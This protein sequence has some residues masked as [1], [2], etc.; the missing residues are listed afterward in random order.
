M[1]NPIALRKNPERK[2]KADVAAAALAGNLPTNRPTDISTGHYC[3]HNSDKQP[4]RPTHNPHQPPRQ[5]QTRPRI[6]DL[7]QAMQI[8]QTHA[9]SSSRP[10]HH[11]RR[12]ERRPLD[13]RNSNALPG[14]QDGES[15]DNLETGDADGDDDEED[16]DPGDASHFLVGDAVGQDLAEVEEDLAALVE[17]LDAGFDFEVFA[18][19]GVEGVEGG[20]RVPEEGGVVEEVRCW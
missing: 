8:P 14:I 15:E 17:D 4:L 6:P 5:Q 11:H 20:F 9:P 1:S 13:R 7:T 16:D 2:E 10:I 18:D 19:G 3:R 12:P